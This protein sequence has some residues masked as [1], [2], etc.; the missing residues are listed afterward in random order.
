MSIGHQIPHTRHIS[1]ISNHDMPSS[2]PFLPLTNTMTSQLND[3]TTTLSNNT[4]P[5]HLFHSRSY[6]AAAYFA[7]NPENHPAS[8]ST[9]SFV[10]Q[11]S[12]MFS[13]PQSSSYDSTRLLGEGD[14]EGVASTRERSST[15]G[16]TRRLKFRR[17]RTGCMVCRKRKVKC[18]QDGNP[19]KQCRI[20]K[21]EC[22]YDDNPTKR[23]RK[24]KTEDELIDQGSASI[25]STELN[26]TSQTNDSAWDDQMLSP[27]SALTLSNLR[28][29]I[30]RSHAEQPITESISQS[31]EDKTATLARK[32]DE[33][34]KR[35]TDALFAQHTNI[36]Q[37][38]IEE[39]HLSGP[40]ARGVKTELDPDQSFA[41]MTG[42]RL[43]DSILSHTSMGST[44]L[45]GTV[46]DS[47]LDS[48]FEAD[49]AK[50]SNH[51]SSSTPLDFKHNHDNT[52][53]STLTSF[54]DFNDGVGADLH[55][56]AEGT[57]SWEK[58]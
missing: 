37:V 46:S 56:D 58:T 29:D 28:A 40:R 25:E 7:R 4:S 36:D 3:N 2:T 24:S 33:E 19:C 44:S 55:Y 51:P 32:E 15:S 45:S 43:D 53:P 38:G 18:D 16:S 31:E 39:G 17:S 54:A 10:P 23:R 6:S 26:S 27:N 9:S 49:F 30:A 42:S 1:S 14:T 12:L 34:L 21:R 13:Q 11:H 48:N 35:K 5:T 22:H 52:A 50:L 57:R 41:D 20:G 47:T 8:S